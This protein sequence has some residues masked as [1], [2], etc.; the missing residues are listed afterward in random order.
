MLR[1]L[2]HPNDLTDMKFYDDKIITAS[3]SGCLRV[4]PIGCNKTAQIL[5]YSQLWNINTG[6]L[7]EST[8]PPQYESCRS[9]AVNSELNLCVYATGAHIIARDMR[10][11]SEIGR[12][13]TTQ[14]YVSRVHFNSDKQI[15]AGCMG[16]HDHS[17]LKVYNWL[18]PK[19]VFT[20]K[21]IA[22][23]GEISAVHCDETKIVYSTSRQINVLNASTYNVT[24]KAS[25]VGS[26][27]SMSVQSDFLV[28]G[29]DSYL[30][31]WS[32]K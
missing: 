16:T 19:P 31:V 1:E 25:I 26:L 6:T 12:I 27:A 3:R 2:P 24:K 15:V 30:G 7:L 9:L 18:A 17:E 21:V 14:T 32:L 13:N 8:P 29:Y 4:S 28:L 5:T 20:Q 11:R 10:M 23:T 22:W